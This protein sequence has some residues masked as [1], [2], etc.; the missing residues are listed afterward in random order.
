MFAL[1]HDIAFY[2]DPEFE[3]EIYERRDAHGL[4][5]RTVVIPTPFESLPAHESLAEITEARR[6]HP[7]IN[8]NPHKDTPLYVALGWSKFELLRRALEASTFEATHFAWIDIGLANVANVD[9]AI[10]DGVFARPG[11]GVRVLMMRAP[12]AVE[13]ADREHYLS[14]IWGQIAAGY[15]STERTC[16]ERLCELAV[17]EALAMLEHGY[18]ATDEHLLAL[19]Y[20]SQPGLFA[21]HYGDYAVILAN[22]HRVRGSADNLL[23]QLRHCRSAERWDRKRAREISAAVIDAC[24][25][26]TLKCTKQLPELLEECFIAIYLADYPSEE[27]AREVVSL[28]MRLAREHPEFRDSFLRNELRVRTNF[29]AV[30]EPVQ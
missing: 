6:R 8:G 20:S 21:F 9:H 23:F 22:Y 14:Y 17:A 7:L 15:I 30:S 19:A 24:R 1:D 18:A 3:H 28:Y 13:L 2:V 11:T 29:S 26:G 16:T 4:L 10:E 5:D 27:A 25:L 12:R